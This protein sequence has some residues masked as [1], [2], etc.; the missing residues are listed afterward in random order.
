MAR[1]VTGLVYAVFEV[2]TVNTHL[3]LLFYNRK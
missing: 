1:H 3:L 2:Y